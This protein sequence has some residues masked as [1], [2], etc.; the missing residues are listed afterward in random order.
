MNGN[1]ASSKHKKNEV[2]YEMEVFLIG[3]LCLGGLAEHW[4]N[5]NGL[6]S[7][8]NALDTCVYTW[9]AAKIKLHPPKRYALLTL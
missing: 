4:H 7:T 6:T 8:L 5:Y 3:I 1:T 9:G 2:W